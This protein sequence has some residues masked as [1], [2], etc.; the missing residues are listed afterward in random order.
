MYTP[1]IDVFGSVKIDGHSEGNFRIIEIS[2]NEI[3]MFADGQTPWVAQLDGPYVTR[4]RRLS[5]TLTDGRTLEFQRA[6]CACQTPASLKGPRS[7][8]VSLLQ[9]ADA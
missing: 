7:K 1:K 2:P 5:A 3:G 8:F 6:G 4:A 9:P